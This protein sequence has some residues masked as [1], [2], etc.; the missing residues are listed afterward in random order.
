MIHLQNP[1]NKSPMRKFASFPPKSVATQT[2]IWCCW[3]F[4]KLYWFPMRQIKINCLP[5]HCLPFTIE[6][7]TLIGF[8]TNWTVIQTLLFFK[9]ISWW[10]EKVY[11]QQWVDLWIQCLFNVSQTLN[12]LRFF[13]IGDDSNHIQF[14]L[15]VPRDNSI[16]TQ[17]IP[18]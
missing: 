8:D 17:F 4:K 7:E 5:C 1:A 11:S 16:Q 12:S 2:V 3:H 6:E 14:F 15:F 10:R 18:K 9:P 13:C